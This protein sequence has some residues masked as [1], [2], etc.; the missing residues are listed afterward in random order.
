MSTWHG[1]VGAPRLLTAET[2][3]ETDKWML[4]FFA[5]CF[6]AMQTGFLVWFYYAYGKIREIKALEEAYCHEHK[7]HIMLDYNTKNAIPYA[8]A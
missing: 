6:I 5:V 1:I 3:L 7:E 8:T 2:A 4:L